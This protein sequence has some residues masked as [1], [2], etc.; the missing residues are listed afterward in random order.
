MGVSVI[1]VFETPL[2]NP[3]DGFFT[4]NKRKC[5]Y[6][7][8]FRFIKNNLPDLEL[9]VHKH[10]YEI[11]FFMPPTSK[12]LEGHIASGLFVRPSFRPSVRPS[13]RHAF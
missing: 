4:E 13:V 8:S 10:D 6:F 7:Q 12:K 1:F 2:G 3:S 9:Q 5:L 11:F